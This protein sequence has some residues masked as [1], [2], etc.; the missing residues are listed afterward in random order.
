MET[1]TAQ[2]KGIR[3]DVLSL[4][5]LPAVRAQELAQLK[6]VL[7]SQVCNKTLCNKTLAL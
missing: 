3:I 6:C 7:L 1:R 4:Q 2:N 5:R